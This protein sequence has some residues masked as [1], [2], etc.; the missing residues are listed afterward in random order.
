V[1]S[2]AC[3]SGA[4]AIG[5]AWEWVRRG[6]ADRVLTGSH[7]VLSQLV[8]AGFDSLQ[9]LSPTRCR[10]FDATRDGLAL[11][12]GAAVLALEGLGSAQ[13]RGAEILG[14]IVGFA[15]AG[16]PHHV[17]QPHPEG[18]AALAAMQAAAAVAG[19]EPGQVSYIN[20]HGTGTML[21]DSAESRAIA[22]WAG[23]A[24]AR[25]P[26]SSTKASVGHTLGAAGGVEAAVCLM[27]LREQWLPPERGIAVTEPLCPCPLVREPR[28][29][30]V[31]IALSNSLGFGGANSTLIF[32]RW[33]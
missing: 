29:A 26:L 22:R 4:D 27:T 28:A 2:H 19:L 12:E 7:D 23:P 24:A 13:R 25:I 3:A 9:L 16:D 32:R 31:D 1:L 8:F 17:A 33:A 21:N 6:H 20:A 14:E 11:G 15:S 5:H 30:R 18:D 10:P